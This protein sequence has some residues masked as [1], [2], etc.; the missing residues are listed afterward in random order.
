MDTFLNILTNIGIVLFIV[1]FFGFCIFIHEFGHL[2]AAVWQ[3][4]H[5][6][7]F[8]IGF[9]KKIWGFK[10]KGIDFIV[11]I[12]PLGG[13]VSI[14]QLDPADQP[15]TED[16]QVLPFST[17]KAR[18]ITA[19]AGPFFNILFGFVL[20]FFL[21]IVGVW[22]TPPTSSVIVLDVPHVIPVYDSDNGINTGEKIIKINGK[23]PIGLKLKQ[24]EYEG[25]LY[26][27]CAFWDEFQADFNLPKQEGDTLKLTV[28]DNE[29]N[30]RDVDYI[31][32]FNPEYKAGLRVG[33]RIVAFNGEPF[34]KGV[35]GLFEAHAYNDADKATITV[36]RE[37]KEP[38]DIA[39]VQ[40]GNS[41]IEDLKIPFFQA[42]NPLTIG[43][44]LKNSPAE[45]AGLMVGDQLL[46]YND[47]P[48]MNVKSFLEYVNKEA[49]GNLKLMIARQGE[50]LPIDVIL[51]E[52][53][54]YTAEKLGIAFIV[55]VKTIFQDLPAEKAGLKLN[56]RLYK[57]NGAEVT[58]AKSFSDTIKKLEG[59][60]FQLIVIR[61]GEQITFDNL[62][63]QITD[64]N[65]KPA[66]ILGIQMDD[67]PPKVIAHPN[68]WTQFTDVFNKTARTLLL[69]FQPVT[70]FVTGRDTGSAPVKLKH[71][72][73]IV[74]ISTMLWY[75]VKVEGI[76][77]GLAFILLITFG[78]AFANLLP[79]PILDG[80]HIMFAGIEF[81]IRRRLPV[82]F[83]T[84]ISNLF[85]GLLIALMLYITFND[86]MRLPRINKAYKSDNPKLIIGSPA[87]KATTPAEKTTTPAEKAT[88]TE[89]AQTT[90]K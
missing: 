35:D 45:K 56:D 23:D 64:N 60:P 28:Q 78:L 3:G 75:S 46:S 32:Q 5:V 39:Y 77:G 15:K 76:R 13:Y 58:D 2:I 81:V 43:D 73:S 84:Y 47:K 86:I 87:E 69:L 41:R 51:A 82:K 53:Q 63:A 59:K 10:Y 48:M 33:D 54:E 30:T 42:R 19:F 4:L 88:E 66:Y 55:T 1:F 8:S 34:S 79:F 18:A 61:H 80:G 62:V 40:K 37:G 68:P 16:G 25:S 65:G 89:P 29:G 72:S 6:D 50:E 31:V 74:G 44:V 67:A 7:K 36:K 57:I 49:K 21:W 11:S 27:L 71:M 26:D 85:A 20:A 90:T 24:G 17:P 83:M 70:N 22:Q 14:P 12:L 52:E 38:F 9:G